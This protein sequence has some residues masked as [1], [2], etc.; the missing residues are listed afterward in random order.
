MIL[1]TFEVKDYLD[2]IEIIT[3]IKPNTKNLILDEVQE[4]NKWEKLVNALKNQG[5]TLLITGSNSKLLSKEFATYLT[6]RHV[7]YALYPFS[8]RE[9]LKYRKVNLNFS[10]R[11]NI[12]KIKNL[13][14]KY[15]NESGFPESYFVGRK[16]LVDIY[17][18]IVEKDLINRYNIK[19]KKTF[20]ELSYYLIGLISS[21]ITFNS[22]KKYFN[23]GS[24]HTAK[25][26]IEYL[27]NA[28]LIYTVPKFS[29][30]FRETIREPR[31]VYYVDVGLAKTLY[32]GISKDKGKIIE[33][34]VFLDLL[35][36]RDYF[37]KDWEVF[38]YKTK[39]NKEIDFVIKEN[40][41]VECLIEVCYDFDDLKTREKHIK[42]VLKALEELKLKEGL[43]ITWDD[44][45]LIEEKGKK[46]R[47]IPLWKWLLS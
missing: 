9:Y 37:L 43:I 2:L 14:E 6:G 3:E 18:S 11:E 35:R 41:K 42:K 20:R 39:D 23:F 30:K 47:V 46:I 13:L 44:E 25:N 17:E 8:F 27:E 31:K 10:L 29:F 33:N 32:P 28:F 36:R 12:G 1:S 15:I 7:K 5:Y 40:K 45:D 22:I 4:I 19:Y 16:Y 26:Y 24:V 21:N 38:Y 34:L